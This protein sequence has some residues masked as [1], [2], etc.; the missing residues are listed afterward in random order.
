MSSAVDEFVV[1][2]HKIFSSVLNVLENTKVKPVRL[3]RPLV[4]DGTKTKFSNSLKIS[5][6]LEVNLISITIKSPTLGLNSWL[7]VSLRVIS[8]CQLHPFITV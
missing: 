3:E 6:R 5:W 8:C 4:D 2:L 1:N 7:A